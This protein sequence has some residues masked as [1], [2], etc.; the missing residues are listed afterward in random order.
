M[1]SNASSRGSPE[2]HTYFVEGVCGGR[3]GLV[4][5]LVGPLEEIQS[6]EH[7]LYKA[8]LEDFGKII[9]HP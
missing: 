9:V 8:K 1:T 2:N 7:P 6:S 3:E 5:V 4:A